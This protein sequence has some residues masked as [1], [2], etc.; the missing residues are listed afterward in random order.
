MTSLLTKIPGGLLGGLKSGPRLFGGGAPRASGG[1][2]FGFFK[3]QATKAGLNVNGALAASKGKSFANIK[4]ATQ[5]GG[6]VAGGAFGFCRPNKGRN[7]L[8]QG[9]SRNVNKNKRVLNN[10]INKQ[11]AN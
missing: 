5:G 2:V 3:G 9:N 1:G 10:N 4:A 11:I 6:N 7:L 8:Y